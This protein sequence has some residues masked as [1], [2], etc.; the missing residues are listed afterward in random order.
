MTTVRRL[1]R[2]EI[3]A[4][5]EY[6]VGTCLTNPEVKPFDASVG[7]A[8]TWVVTVEASLSRPLE[9]VPVKAYGVDGSR[10]YARLGAVVLLRRNAQGRFEAVAPGDRAAAFVEVKEYDFGDPTP[11]AT[12]T[13]GFTSR[14]E[15]FEFYQG[16][17][18]PNSLWNDGV[19]PFPKVTVVD[20][21]GDPV[22]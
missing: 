3:R 16:S 12:E 5:R 13:L 6:L 8:P 1:I 18:P 21:N 14:R 4:R 17:G 2:Q 9:D 11:T 22:P 10:A 20:P 15:P 19:T 7:G